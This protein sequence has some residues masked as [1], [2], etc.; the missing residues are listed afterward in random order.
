MTQQIRLGPRE[1][2]LLFTLEKEGKTTFSID[3]VKRI[4]KGPESS[5]W[6]VV[7]RLKR[8]NR[9]EEMQRGKYLLVPAKAGMEAN[10][11]EFPFLIVPSLVSDY[12][13]GLWSALSYWRMTEQ[14][15]LT[16][17]VVTCKRK[18]EV[19]FGP[20]TF[21]FITFSRRRYFGSTEEKIANEKFLISSKEKT[22]IDCLLFPQYC[23]GMEEIVKAITISRSAID[24]RVL[25]K[26]IEQ[27]GSNVLARRL[28]YLSELVGDF[29]SISRY[30]AGLDFSGYRWF[31]P[32][33]P[34]KVFSISREYGLKVNRSKKELESWMRI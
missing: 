5:S 1:L 6:N 33:G 20:T 34:K 25:S 15:P 30:I 9:I 26:G 4:L 18:R 10:W 7:Y 22:L 13:I 28:G 17:F 24:F 3:D 12:Y 19:T 16:V 23:G 32:L 31:D 8:K 14:V 11:S 2:E 27:I 29:H 21:R